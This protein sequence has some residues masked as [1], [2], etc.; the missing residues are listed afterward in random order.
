VNI[1]KNSRGSEGVAA[2]F[3]TFLKK[4]WKINI[5]NAQFECVNSSSSTSQ[6][7]R[8]M[9]TNKRESVYTQQVVDCFLALALQ[10]V[11]EAEASRD[12]VLLALKF[13]VDY[14]GIGRIKT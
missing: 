13:A 5:S 8:G 10:G 9:A 11:T 14:A 6:V 4:S 7:F 1:H 2:Y 12:Y 3:P